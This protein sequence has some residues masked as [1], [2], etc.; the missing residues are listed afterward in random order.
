MTDCVQI[1]WTAESMEEA[2][3]ISTALV[4][5]KLVAC[6]NLIPHVESIYEW[7]GRIEHSKE[8]KVLFK[9][10]DTLFTKVQAFI[11][12]N[13][14]YDAPAILKFEIQEGSASYLH[15]IKTSIIL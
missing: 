11:E 8:V 4:E 9:T 12:E 5:Q 10:K 2:K 15:W 3:E 7:E 6:A 13:F 1:E 14:S